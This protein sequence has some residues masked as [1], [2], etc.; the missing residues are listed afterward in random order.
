VTPI[1]YAG[2]VTKKDYIR[3]LSTHNKLLN[4]QKW[5]FGFFLILLVIA[6][7]YSGISKSIDMAGLLPGF[8]FMLLIF[9]FPWWTQ[10]IQLLSFNREG[11]IYRENVFGSINDSGISI[12]N[13]NVKAEF[14]WSSYKG[15][16]IKDDLILLYQ[17]NNNFS[18]FM[19]SMF[20][21]DID[22]T[23]FLSIVKEKIP[24]KK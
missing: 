10:Y 6:Y 21:T 19:K 24:L 14:Q 13:K 7:L 9:T 2:K 12:N 23:N 5:F 3:V 15:Y 16:R 8:L 11:M 1:N 18:I 4:L 17:G 22:W 20:A